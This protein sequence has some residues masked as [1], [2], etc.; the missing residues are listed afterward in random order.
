MRQARTYLEIVWPPGHGFLAAWVFVPLSAGGTM[1]SRP[2]L[3]IERSRIYKI[4]KFRA[5][6]HDRRSPRI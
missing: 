1:G 2:P 5:F 6:N 4:K 3:L